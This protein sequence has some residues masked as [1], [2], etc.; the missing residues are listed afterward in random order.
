MEQMFGEEFFE[1]NLVEWI[2]YLHDAEAD[3]IGDVRKLI[4]D[5][6]LR[7]KLNERSERIRGFSLENGEWAVLSA[8]VAAE[9]TLDSG[10]EAATQRIQKDWDEI[11][12]V[13]RSE[14][15]GGMP[16]TFEE[17]IKMARSGDIPVDAL[18]ELGGIQ[19]CKRCGNEILRP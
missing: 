11:V 4:E 1:W 7:E 18:R 8:L 10:M 14:A 9:A 15:L 16:E 5:D 19:D 17:F 12:A 3:K 13:A 2:R 6:E